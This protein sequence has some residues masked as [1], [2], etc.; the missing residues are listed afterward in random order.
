MRGALQVVLIVA[1]FA[2]WSGVAL[3]EDAKPRPSIELSLEERGPCSVIE[4]VQ[5]T[6][7]KR[8]R[9]L[10]EINVIKRVLR[11]AD[12]R[13]KLGEL[14]RLHKLVTELINSDRLTLAALRTRAAAAC[15][16]SSTAASVLR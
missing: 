2:A 12:N 7:Q 11:N 14:V 1:S 5:I 8:E 4:C 3:A 13:P 15:T 6:P 16:S 9:I 10:R